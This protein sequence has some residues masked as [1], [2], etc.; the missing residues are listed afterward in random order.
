MHRFYLRPDQC[1]GPA[2]WL[3]DGEAHHAQ[4]VLR[5][6]R[7]VQ[8]TVLDGAGREFLCEVQD[9]ARDGV[10]LAILESRT[11]TPPACPITLIQSLPKGKIIE[12]IIQKATE[13][14]VAR[15]VP[16]ITERVVS[17]FEEKDAARKRA[18]LQSVAVEAIKQCGSAWLPQIETPMILNQ[19]L[20]RGEPFE[21]P[22]I[23]SLQGD[24]KPPQE[25]FRTFQARHGRRPQSACVW[26]GPEGDFT[27]AETAAIKTGGALPITLGRLV[28]RVET[29]AIYCLSILRYELEPPA[30]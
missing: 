29:A 11:H 30:A 7:G 1:L 23:A 17:Q 28:L 2:L 13:L 16:L 14:G 24:G 9:C 25:Y 18:K 26:V 27:P 20:A 15:V 3:T 8:V 19:F 5:V 6:R 22:L 12:T 4:H 10:R 21:L